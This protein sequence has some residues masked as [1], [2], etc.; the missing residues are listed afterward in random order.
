M[1]GT[2]APPTAIR[3]VRFDV[4]SIPK[5]PRGPSVRRRIKVERVSSISQLGAVGT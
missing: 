5:K 3:V 1:T 2:I 4:R